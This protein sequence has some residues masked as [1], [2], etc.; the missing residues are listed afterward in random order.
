MRES[1][2]GEAEL[3]KLFLYQNR[4]FYNKTFEE[5]ERASWNFYPDEAYFSKVADLWSFANRLLPVSYPK[6]IFKFRN[7]EEANKHRDQWDLEHAK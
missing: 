5:A 3:L 4:G 2:A 1:R 7:I 6:G